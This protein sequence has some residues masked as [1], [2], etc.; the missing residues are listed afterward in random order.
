LYDTH[1]ADVGSIVT[2]SVIILSHT[3]SAEEP[4][5]PLCNRLNYRYVRVRS[6]RPA[7]SCNCEDYRNSGLIVWLEPIVRVT[8][9]GVPCISK[10]QFKIQGHYFFFWQ[11]F[12]TATTPRMWA[13]EQWAYTVTINKPIGS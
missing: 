11:L 5:L 8:H 6:T 12:T 10:L 3:L 7:V 4:V 2:R 9:C 1:Y 13:V